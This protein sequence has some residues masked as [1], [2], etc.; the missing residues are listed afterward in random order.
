MSLLRRFFYNLS[1]FR[2]PPWDT[3]VPPPELVQF[4]ESHS[5]GRALDAGCGTGTN[6]IYLAEHGW[7]VVGIDY[8]FQ[9]IR[10]ARRK[11]RQNGIEIE[12]FAADV[13]RME[14][15]EGPFD[16]ILDMGCY[17]S[18]RPKERSAYR[19]N[20]K[21]W[22]ATNGYFL[23]Y[24]FIHSGAEDLSPGLSNEDFTLFARDFE[25]TTRLD[26][27]D[28]GQRSSTWLTIKQKSEQP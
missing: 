15:L 19:K 9:A 11:A 22:L 17:H 23:L 3:G 18:L 20:L 25:I 5:A 16:L 26:G 13:T 12:L 4:V 8:A 14:R 24:G 21:R 10:T 28:R 1:Y 6:V 7:K 27:A 2:H